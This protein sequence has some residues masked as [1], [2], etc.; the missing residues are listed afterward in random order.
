MHTEV[1]MF[2]LAESYV[3][4]KSLYLPIPSKPMCCFAICN[5]KI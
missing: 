1:K 2:P 4:L 3:C 5:G